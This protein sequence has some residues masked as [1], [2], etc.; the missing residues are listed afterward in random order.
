MIHEGHGSLKLKSRHKGKKNYAFL[1]KSA[2]NENL[3]QTIMEN[4]LAKT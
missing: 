2:K 1:R 4:I 3:I